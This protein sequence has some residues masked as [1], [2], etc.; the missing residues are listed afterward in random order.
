MIGK[1][2][3]VVVFVGMGMLAGIPL[4]AAEQTEPSSTHRGAVARPC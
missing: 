1:T 3:C 4:F 2:F